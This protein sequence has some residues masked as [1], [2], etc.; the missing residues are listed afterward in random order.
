MHHI[1]LSC[2]AGMDIEAIAAQTSNK[3]TPFETTFSDSFH[4]LRT[5]LDFSQL[6]N[7]LFFSCGLTFWFLHGK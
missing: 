2:Q 7:L 3:D 5:S 4:T 1:G 6:L